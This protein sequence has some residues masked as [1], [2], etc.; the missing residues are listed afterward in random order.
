M[1]NVHR[2][3]TSSPAGVTNVSNI[4]CII[5]MHSFGC[6]IN[7]RHYTCVTKKLLKVLML[8]FIHQCIDI[9]TYCTIRWLSVTNKNFSVF[10]SSCN[11]FQS[12][13]ADFV[14]YFEINF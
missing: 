1:F 11:M 14:L 9:E 10:I 8:K 2:I 5:Y 4:H 3:N 6:M 13:F 12:L 7:Y